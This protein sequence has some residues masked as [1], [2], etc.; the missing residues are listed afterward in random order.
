MDEMKRLILNG[1]EKDRENYFAIE[2]ERMWNVK[3]MGNKVS[4]PINFQALKREGILPWHIK[5]LKKYFTVSGEIRDNVTYYY[6][7]DGEKL[8]IFLEESE[9]VFDWKQNL[10]AF[11]FKVKI[12]YD[13]RRYHLGFFATALTVFKDL[14]NKEL[15][16][17]ETIVELY[18]YSHGAGAVPGLYS[19]IK[20][21][22]EAHPLETVKKFEPP[23]DVFYPNKWIKEECKNHF[24]FIQGSDIVT[25]VPWWMKSL[26]INIKIKGRKLSWMKGL[27]RSV[28]DHD[29][30]WTDKRR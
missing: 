12:G 22:S 6:Y 4:I 30:Y 2:A 24:N 1:S 21:N 25:K 19:M 10:M 8:E 5:R 7:Q 28:F 15:L 14:V 16:N 13:Y 26:G 11:N 9:G 29:I 23:R 27:L 20:W 3:Y 17:K 18:G